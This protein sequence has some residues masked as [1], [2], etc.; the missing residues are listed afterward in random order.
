VLKAAGSPVMTGFS[1]L[2]GALAWLSE[3]E[4]PQ[5]DR[6]NAVD[7]TATAVVKRAVSDGTV[8]G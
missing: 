7:K 5:D 8:P 6:S 2:C 4:L 1:S 3:G